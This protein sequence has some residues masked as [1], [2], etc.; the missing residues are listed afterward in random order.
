MPSSRVHL[1]SCAWWSS[2]CSFRL[3]RRATTTVWIPLSSS[4][5]IVPTPEWVITSSAAAAAADL[6]YVEAVF[7]ALLTVLRPCRR[8]IGTMAANR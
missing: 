6:R 4:E 2:T 1:A 7:D 5:R 8:V 3:T